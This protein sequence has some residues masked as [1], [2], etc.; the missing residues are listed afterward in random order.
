M[1]LY[2]VSRLIGTT[3]LAVPSAVYMLDSS[4][5]T[6]DHDL[7]HLYPNLLLRDV[8]QDLCKSTDPTPR[9]Y[10]CPIHHADYMAPT[11]NVSC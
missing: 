5:D 8:V 11:R 2:S 6:S 7:D 9:I 10:M 3:L 1:L 4:S